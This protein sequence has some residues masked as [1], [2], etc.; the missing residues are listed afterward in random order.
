MSSTIEVLLSTTVLL[1][2]PIMFAALGELVAERAGIL[3]ISI[4][5]T[6]L[7]GCFSA[8]GALQLGW[9]LVAAT[10]VA[11]PLGALVG[12]LLSWLYITR[13]VNQI[14]GGVLFNMLALGLTTSLFVSYF[15]GS[16]GGQ[17]FE[18]VPLPLLSEIPILG[19]SLFDQPVLVYL[20]VLSIP[21]VA[22]LVRSTW[23][24]LHLR[25]AGE[26]PE[27]VDSVGV[28]V[29]SIRSL[30]LIAGSALIALGGASLVVLQSGAFTSNMTAGK[31]FIALAIVMVARWRPA[32]VIPAA[33]LFAFA[34]SFQ[35]K[36]QALGVVAV[37]PQ[38]W[39]ILPYALTILAVTVGRAARYPAAI[40]TSF[41]RNG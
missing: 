3:N 7:L 25:A 33:A 9:G 28:D 15:S 2:V 37:A 20:G 35:Y 27:S 38:L 31:G 1:F 23:F 32:L 12:A 17:L 40:G 34:E 14:V 4:E 24:G 26:R 6:M 36:A 8:A 22:W 11:L 39:A 13:R 29:R 21:L 19:P 30:S 5:G 41:D 10:L 18:A 16:R